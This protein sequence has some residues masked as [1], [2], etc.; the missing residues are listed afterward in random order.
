MDPLIEGAAQAAGGVPADWSAL[1]AGLMIFRLR[2]A[3]CLY[4]WKLA[5]RIGA[6]QSL[7]SRIE[8]GADLRLSTLR[9]IFDALGCDLVLLPRPRRA[10]DVLAADNRSEEWARRQRLPW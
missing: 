7:I 9:R 4:Q 3:L 5:M 1:P 10:L 6:R 2:T 8:H